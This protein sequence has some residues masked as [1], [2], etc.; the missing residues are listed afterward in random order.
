MSSLPGTCDDK[1][2][3]IFQ[4]GLEFNI[5]GEN[6]TEGTKPVC[7]VVLKICW[8]VDC[9]Q[10]DDNA[11]EE[12]H[13]GEQDLQ[14]LL[15]THLTDR[16]LSRALTIRVNTGKNSDSKENSGHTARTETTGA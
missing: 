8:Q 1:K 11:D 4:E 2:A 9:A 15:V 3:Y 13:R 5:H 16:L 6:S 10:R 14:G 12:F 7:Q